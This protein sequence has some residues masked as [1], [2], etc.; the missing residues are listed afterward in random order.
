MN[1]TRD[2]WDTAISRRTLVRR[3]VLTGLSGVAFAPLLAACGGTTPA[4][5]SPT[6]L[7]TV[8]PRAQPTMLP[9]TSAASTVP[10]PTVPQPTVPPMAPPSAQPTMPPPPTVA[11]TTPATAATTAP[12]VGATAAA[13][14]D[15]ATGSAAPA[16]APAPI[17]FV[18]GNG[19]SAAL[20]ITTLWRFEANGYPRERLFTIDY[21][22]PT[23]RDDDAIPQPSRSG[24]DEQRTQLAARVDT[25]LAQTGAPQLIL[26]GN[27]RGANSIRNYV[28]NGGAARVSHVVLGGGVNHGVYVM[29]G[30]NSEF[31]GAGRFLQML[32][33]GSEVVPGV[34]FL[35][36]RSDRFDKYA[37][38]M[39]AS[40]G[41]SG[42]GYDAPA[43]AGATNIVLEGIDH[44][45]TAFGPRAFAEM[46]R[47][48]TGRVG[49]PEIMLEAGVRLSGLITGFEN[50]V[51]TNGGVAGIGVTVYETDPAT[52]ARRG[53]PAYQMTTGGDGAWGPFTG[54]PTAQYEFVVQQPGGPVR[55]FFRSPFPRSSS[56]V[57]M[58][59]F[60]DAPLPDGGQVIFTRPRGYVA[61]GRD[62]HLLDGAPVPGVKEGVPTDASFKVPITGSERGVRASLNGEALTVRAIPGEV[63][64]AE[65]H[66]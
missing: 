5:T 42:I 25:V 24:T 65:F 8:P 51:P 56:V 53:A 1:E 66:Y 48:V 62:K 52:G 11:R 18:H 63:V 28:K 32:N 20:W 17:L 54:Q 58:R 7:P 27:S 43:L 55:H 22:N 10:Q 14:R 37:Q 23:A 59:L 41:P 2:Q 29:P 40:G 47:F 13:S 19:D 64:Y 45:E 16:S 50:K 15:A 46:F 44:R 9:P 3:G 21:P 49:T 57:S 38:P 60:E 33:A 4:N 61:T 31:N 36:I 34:A 39:L 35:T 12:T 26:I 6:T 30:N